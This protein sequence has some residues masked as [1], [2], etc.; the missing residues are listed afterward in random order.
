M[1]LPLWIEVG[2]KG[3]QIAADIKN[4]RGR[5]SYFGALDYDKREFLLQVYNNKADSQSMR[6]FIEYLRLEKK[7]QRIAIFWDGADYRCCK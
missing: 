7:E 1:R 3:E 2:G 5:R 4:I 6:A